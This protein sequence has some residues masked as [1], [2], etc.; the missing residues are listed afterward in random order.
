M[1]H[2]GLLKIFV[3]NFIAKV[4]NHA[5]DKT[6]V[7][8]HLG[9]CIRKPIHDAGAFMIEGVKGTHL[10]M[11]AVGTTPGNPCKS[12]D[13]KSCTRFDSAQDQLISE[14]E[15]TS[16]RREPEPAT[17]TLFQKS[18]RCR[19][20]GP[21]TLRSLV[22]RILQDQYTACRIDDGE[23]DTVAMDGIT[24]ENAKALVANDG[25]WKPD[26]TA[27]RIFSFSLTIF[28]NDAK[29]LEKIKETIVEGFQL[30][31]KSFGGELPDVARE[32]YTAIID[33]LEDWA[34]D[35][36]SA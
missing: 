10:L 4:L 25:H 19:D 36:D 8:F 27:A 11:S 24:P 13:G 29:K 15:V 5:S 17:Y 23:L 31:R 6:S 20:C 28:R 35:P 16:D 14:D 1:T 18:L 22:L 9:L 3:F 33:R 21:L 7:V 12:E 30:A 2:T 26:Q 34:H 32:T